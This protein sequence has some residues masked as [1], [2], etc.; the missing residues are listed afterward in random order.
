MIVPS[1]RLLGWV[2]AVGLPCAAVASTLADAALLLAGVLGLLAA[3]GLA[4]A[5]RGW[6]RMAGLR[7]TAPAVVRMACGREGQVLLRVH[8]PGPGVPAV[9]LGLASPPDL[10]S[11]Q[12]V[13]AA[14]LPEPAKDYLVP[15]ACRPRRRG[16]FGLALCGLEFDSP[17][18]LWQVRRR[19][20][21]ASEVRVY[22][23]LRTE[24]RR[25]AAVFLRRGALGIH[26]W[27]Q[28]G[29]GRE[30]EKLREYIP[31]DSY[32][33]IHWKATARRRHPVTKIFQIERTQEVYVVLDSSR[34][35]ARPA[36]R[37]SGET[38][39]DEPPATMLDRFI[40]AGLTLV[41]AAEA[42]G[43]R[44]GLIEFSG[45]VRTFV[46][47]GRG[48]A[49]FDACR[50]ALYTAAPERVSPSYAEL[51]SFIRTRLR[52]RALLVVLTSLDDSIL[53]EAFLRGVELVRRQHLVTVHMMRP[54]GAQP[55]FADA[56]V[57]AVEDLYRRLEGHATWSRLQQT[58]RELGRLGISFE[59]MD[60][61]RL[62]AALVSQYMMIKNRQMI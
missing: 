14:A 47:S 33:D 51:F 45:R 52:R 26:R 11:A 16:R 48:K 57:D 5:W 25:V 30:F 22:P 55:L 62:S 36:P 12:G 31:G 29:K 15:W 3:A 38:G 35:S 19:Q 27:R 24:R 20:P 34:L 21:L 28:V 39:T 49:H 59:P 4:D 8:A 42:Q 44:F 60:H 6:R 23:D 53:A 10:G 7:V 54:P 37:A 18:G 1:P 13:V 43:D 17:W 2:A 61:E 41:L 40:A 56:N 9:R 46:R 58:A 50:N 32:E